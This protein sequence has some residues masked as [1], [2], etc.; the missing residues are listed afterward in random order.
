MNSNPISENE[1]S[2][3][4]KVSS[5]PPAQMNSTAQM[6]T[7]SPSQPSKR[8]PPNHIH[9]QKKV[10]K[11]IVVKLEYDDFKQYHMKQGEKE[12]DVDFDERCLQVW[13]KLC[14]KGKRGCI[15]LADDEIDQD[16]NDDLEVEIEVEVEDAV[17]EVDVDNEC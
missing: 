6:N 17:D 16:D 12:C 15:E 1:F 10:V 4:T 11:Y 9:F 14:D 13:T 3:S 2:Q 8:S 5:I 7:L